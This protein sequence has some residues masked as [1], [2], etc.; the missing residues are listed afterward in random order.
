[1]TYKFYTTNGHCGMMKIGRGLLAL[2]LVGA[3]M[4]TSMAL[5]AVAQSSSSASGAPEKIELLYFH[6][7]DRC[8]SCN[9]A[10][11]YARDTLNAY[12]P[13]ELR[14]GKL[15]IQSIDYQKDKTMADK[16]GVNMQGLKL[17][18]VNGGQE[19]IKDLPE[20][21]TYVRDRSGYMDYLRNALDDALGR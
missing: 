2:L 18:I 3:V 9:N 11:Q 15:S 5:N 16:Y 17:R 13:D 21:W 8:Q 19:T 1:M 20:L 10:E 6:R 12:F 14:S 7:T 4:A